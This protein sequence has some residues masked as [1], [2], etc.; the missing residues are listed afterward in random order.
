MWNKYYE[1]K[2]FEI[3]IY[4]S[5]KKNS[6]CQINFPSEIEKNFENEAHN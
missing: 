4:S 5:R 6:R 2:I 1:G 3:H